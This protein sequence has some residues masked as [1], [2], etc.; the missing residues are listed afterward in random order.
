MGRFRCRLMRTAGYGERRVGAEQSLG[1]DLE[2][3]Q[4]HLGDYDDISSLYP[5]LPSRS[6]NASAEANQQA[7]L[8]TKRVNI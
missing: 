8:A 7:K 5:F 1:A 2:R 3:A 6:R 4:A